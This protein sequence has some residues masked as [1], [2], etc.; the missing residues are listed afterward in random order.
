[1][2]LYLE[3]ETNTELL[4]RVNDYLNYIIEEEDVPFTYRKC[5]FKQSYLSIPILIAAQK[6]K[7]AMGE[8]LRL[9]E[10]RKVIVTIT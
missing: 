4:E 5:K 9:K 1:M 7:D 2:Y 8:I 10:S 3:L 6:S